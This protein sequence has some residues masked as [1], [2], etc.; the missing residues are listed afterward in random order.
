MTE[1]ESPKTLSRLNRF[2]GFGGTIAPANTPGQNSVAADPPAPGSPGEAASAG[3]ISSGT[4]RP[5]PRFMTG[6]EIDRA[7]A[8]GTLGDPRD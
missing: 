5:R 8:N 6:E 1:N 7:I 2:S 4:A 3:N